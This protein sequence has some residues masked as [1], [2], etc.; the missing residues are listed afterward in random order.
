MTGDLSYVKQIEVVSVRLLGRHRGQLVPL[1]SRRA[2]QK[3]RQALSARLATGGRHSVLRASAAER[4]A[5][6]RRPC[7]T[8]RVAPR[9]PN[10]LV[11][12]SGASTPRARQLEHSKQNGNHLPGAS[13]EPADD[14][15]ATDARRATPRRRGGRSETQ[16]RDAPNGQIRRKRRKTEKKNKN[17]TLNRCVSLRGVHSLLFSLF[18][19][20]TICLSLFFSLHFRC[21]LNETSTQQSRVIAA[22]TRFFFKLEINTRPVFT[23]MSHLNEGFSSGGSA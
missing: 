14:A 18:L 4:G 17:K 11:S 8:T 20:T 19:T 23:Q 7:R 16:E 2:A 15:R 1:T 10:C 21:E 6:R 3:A 9:Y 22:N 12:R 5:L 13:C